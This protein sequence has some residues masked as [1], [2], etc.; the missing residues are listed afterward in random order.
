MAML[1]AAPFQVFP[2]SWQIQS[3]ILF[4]EAVGDGFL[5]QLLWVVLPYS[6]CF[7]EKGR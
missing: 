2:P 3:P 7:S 1:A 4:D 5:C 6:G